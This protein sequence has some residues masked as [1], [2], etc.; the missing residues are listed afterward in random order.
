MSINED[1]LMGL[2]TT[3]SNMTLKSIKTTIH[4]LKLETPDGDRQ[5]G[6][7]SAIKDILNIIDIYETISFAK[8]R[9]QQEK[10]N[11]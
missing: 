4:S 2:I 9:E 6:Y 5:E 10:T 11:E 7:Q 1:A 3:G 8:A